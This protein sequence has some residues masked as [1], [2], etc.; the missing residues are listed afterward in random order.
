MPQKNEKNIFQGQEATSEK[1]INK[2]HSS[3]THSGYG[4]GNKEEDSRR[5]LGL[6]ISPKIRTPPKDTCAL[7]LA[8]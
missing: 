1:T 3:L 8:T 2:G 7:R 6:Y 4:I 5:T